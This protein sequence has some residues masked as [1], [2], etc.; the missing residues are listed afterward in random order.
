MA[1]QTTLTGT[2]CHTVLAPKTRADPTDS[3]GSLL[4]QPTDPTYRPNL[5]NQP[6]TPAYYSHVRPSP[7]M[8]SCLHRRRLLSGAARANPNPN[9]N[10]NPKALTL[11]LSSLSLSLT[12]T[13]TRCCSCC[14]ATSPPPVEQ[15]PARL[16]SRRLVL[17]FNFTHVISRFLRLPSYLF[18][19][20]ARFPNTLLPPA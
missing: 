13:L 5:P 2:L 14:S 9:P 19:F 16:C 12:L 10:P 8:D 20:A 4:T 17:Y 6:A 7:C 15:T 11:T 3:W 1:G 18:A